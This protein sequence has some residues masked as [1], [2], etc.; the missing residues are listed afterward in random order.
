MRDFMVLVCASAASVIIGIGI[1]I[2]SKKAATERPPE[3]P[4]IHNTQF[5][6]QA[7]EGPPMPLIHSLRNRYKIGKQKQ[8]DKKQLAAKAHTDRLWKRILIAVDHGDKVVYFNSEVGPPW[9]MLDN[10]VKAKIRD[11]IDNKWGC[12]FNPDTGRISGWADD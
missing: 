5:T 7:E 8:E 2:T 11:T 1:V 9:D 10:E 6:P 12:T 3:T 4:R